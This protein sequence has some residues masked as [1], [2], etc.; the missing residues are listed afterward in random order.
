MLI[1]DTDHLS[2]I[3]KDTIA[4][5][6]I[7]RRLAAVPP[8][9]VAVSIITYEEQ[10]RGWL[11]YIAQANNSSRQV[12]AYQKLRL[13]V[14]YFRLIP[15]IDYDAAASAEFERLR[16]ERV[17]IGAM[18]LKIASICLAID[19]TLLTRNLKDFGKVPGLRAEDWSA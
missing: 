8:G 11:S 18:D 7:G 16:Q 1:L 10:M 17:R 4:A 2:L 12:E 13:F 5:F 6:N 3:D 19:A 15:L 9:E 14:E